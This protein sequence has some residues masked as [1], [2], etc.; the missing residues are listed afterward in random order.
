MSFLRR[1]GLGTT[2]VFLL[3]MLFH[4]K[5][6][7]QRR[8]ASVTSWA[9]YIMRIAALTAVEVSLKQQVYQR[10]RQ[11]LV[12]LF[13]SG[14]QEDSDSSRL[15]RLRALLHLQQQGVGWMGSGG[16][17]VGRLCANT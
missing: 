3:D 15:A 13:G 7:E 10:Y 9:T 8:P 4:A 11:F 14:A 2:Q 17:G 16:G 12:G 6:S 5:R 1:V